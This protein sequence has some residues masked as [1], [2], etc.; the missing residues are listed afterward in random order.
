MKDKFIRKITNLLKKFFKFRKMNNRFG[1]YYS[2]SNPTYQNL[3]QHYPPQFQQSNP[4][5]YSSQQNLYQQ[6]RQTQQRKKS[7]STMMN[8]Y[9]TSRSK[10]KQKSNS[11][12]H[13]QFLNTLY[14]KIDEML[15]NGLNAD[16]VWKFISNNKGFAKIP[17][18]IADKIYYYIKKND[19]E[20]NQT[21]T[22]SNE[23]QSDMEST[24]E[25]HPIACRS[26]RKCITWEFDYFKYL[27]NEEGMKP[28]E[29]FDIIEAKCAEENYQKTYQ[30]Y[31]K[32]FY[33][34]YV[35]NNLG[36]LINYMIDIDNFEIESAFEATKD[37]LNSLF[38]IDHER[39]LIQKC[40]KELSKGTFLLFKYLLERNFE[41]DEALKL[42][43]DI[44][45]HIDIYDYSK[46]F[47][48]YFAEK[49][50]KHILSNGKIA[51]SPKYYF[52][53]WYDK[54]VDD[55]LEVLVA[56]L[57]N[58]EQFEIDQAFDM[59]KQISNSGTQY[60]VGG[61][62]DVF[63]SNDI[64]RYYQ[65]LDK[66]SSKVF[67]YLVLV[68]GLDVNKALAIAHQYL[69]A[70]VTNQFA[71]K[72]ANNMMKNQLNTIGKRLN[73]LRLCCREII[74]NPPIVPTG[75]NSVNKPV[76]CYGF[77]DD[78]IRKINRQSRYSKIVYEA[79]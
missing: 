73:Y 68:R 31:S 18:E 12:Q 56:Y 25:I 55:N 38:E 63:Q 29:A 13:E 2:Q 9:G 66:G 71:S 30:M 35:Q 48:D 77:T 67:D 79:K 20:I 60:G 14:S 24:E 3:Y 22:Q 5:Q 72:F 23:D 19:F 1:N 7:N 32:S 47:A 40:R 46:Q 33:K 36:L 27:T 26:C 53:Y 76:T 10:N 11:I 62:D 34:K 49:Y 74:Q 65:N 15:S 69:D 41:V 58:E 44:E 6:Q 75:K 45:N 59:I 54:Y 43:K 17:K 57:V 8:Y 21:D 28:K 4:M 52:N 16:E 51:K 61:D 42:S 78:E 50:S 70:E 39:E 64:S 37:L